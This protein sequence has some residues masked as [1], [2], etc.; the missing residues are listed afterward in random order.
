MPRLI[1][2]YPSNDGNL[3]YGR[4][5]PVLLT[6]CGDTCE[7]IFYVIRWVFARWVY[8]VWSSQS[9]CIFHE[10]V[11]WWALI[12]MFHLLRCVL[13]V[14]HVRWMNLCYRCA[15]RKI[16]ILWS[17]YLLKVDPIPPLSLYLIALEVMFLKAFIPLCTRDAALWSKFCS[18]YFSLVPNLLSS[19]VGSRKSLYIPRGSNLSP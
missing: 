7:A 9:P 5:D 10:E 13:H 3:S 14:S 19:F 1:N 2:S 16:T 11:T 8:I 15:V 18:T 4:L 17:C 12:R 6:T